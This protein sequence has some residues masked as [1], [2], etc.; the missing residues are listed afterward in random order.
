MTA[1]RLPFD[2][3]VPPG[4]SSMMTRAEVEALPIGIRVR[5]LVGGSG[6]IYDDDRREVFREFLAGEIVTILDVDYYDHAGRLARTSRPPSPPARKSNSH[7][8]R[9]TAGAKLP[10]TSCLG[11]F[12][13]PAARARGATRHCR[14]P[15]TCTEADVSCEGAN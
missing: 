10:A 11:A 2:L 4:A 14:R 15:K 7:S 1:Q 9:G 5:I 8:A 6:A 12:W 13:T 3:T